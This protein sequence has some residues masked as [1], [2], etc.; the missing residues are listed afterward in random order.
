M[1]QLNSTCQ[2]QDPEGHHC[3][4]EDNDS[5]FCCWHD[6]KIDKST[7]DVK[8]AL[9]IYAQKGGLLRGIQ[10]K[11]TNLE[12]IDL[13]NHHKKEGYDFSYADFY[14]TNLKGAHLFNINFCHTSLMKA[15]LRDAN[16]NCANLQNTNMLG[17]KWQGGKFE[18]IKI[19]QKLTQEYLAKKAIKNNDTPLANDYYQ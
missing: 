3:K 6:K 19:S 7:N 15:D 10:L 13:V 9:E 1:S 18:N 11:H 5:G 8:P 2:Y 17:V 12:K 14:Y 16:L 4:G